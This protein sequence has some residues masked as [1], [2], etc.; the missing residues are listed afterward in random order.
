LFIVVAIVF[1]LQWEKRESV[2]EMSKKK[3]RRDEGEKGKK[4][5]VYWL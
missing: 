5:R 3:E 4:D 1:L 2:T